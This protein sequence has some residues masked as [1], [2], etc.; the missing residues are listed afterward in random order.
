[1][2][3]SRQAFLPGFDMK[4]KLAFGGS[5]LKSHPKEARTLVFSQ[6]IHLVMRSTKARGRH[7]FLF[8]AQGV[9]RL[10]RLQAEKANVRVYDI[11]NAGN[12]L[13]LII[14]VPSPR[15]YRRFIRSLS[16]LLVRKVMGTQRGK[17]LNLEKFWDARPFT[18][19]VSWGKDYDG[20]KN[21]LEINRGEVQGF[22]R[23]EMRFILRKI[24]ELERGERLQ[25]VG[26]S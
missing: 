1:M 16:G 18:R 26:F 17:P 11:A 21:Y 7:S 2:K 23:M 12:H 4:K 15:L 14:K 10:I 6:A 13:H 5:S 3:R 19:I 25:A 8:Q 20:L 22:E 9:E 24:A